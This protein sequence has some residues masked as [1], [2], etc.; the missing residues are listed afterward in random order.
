MRSC[1]SLALFVLLFAT[2]SLSVHAQLRAEKGLLNATIFDFTNQRLTLQGEWLWYDNQLL[3]PE[4]LAD[5]KPVPVDF[6]STFNDTRVSG[7]G[8]GFATYSLTVLVPNSVQDYAIELPQIYSSYRLWVNEA[9]VASNGE[10][11]LTAES[12]LPQWRPQTV[13]FRV[14]DTLK[15]VLQVAN[16]HHNKGGVKE[17]IYLGESNTMQ[18]KNTITVNSKIIECSV[19]ILLAVIFFIIYFFYGRKKVI[20]YFS[21]LCITWAVRSAFS[22]DY[23]FIQ[24]VPNF[25]WTSMVRIE[26]ITLYLT[27][28]WAIL[29]LS[30]LFAHEGSQIIK[31]VLVTLNSI[32]VAFTALN[33]PLYFTKLLAVYLVTSALLL[34]YGTIIVVRALIN[35]RIGSTFL[36]ISTLLAVALFSYD[37]ITYEGL[38]AYN[39]ILFSAGYFLIFALMAVALLLHLNI[40]KSSSDTSDMLTYKDLY[41]DGK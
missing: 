40:I 36:S 34:L 18:M 13:S 25:N 41:G 17:P 8:Q 24:L 20:V 19:L 14:K 30:R 37:I 33:P 3:T 39:S 2:S 28:I 10:P 9:L 11:G 38:F 32:F 31:Y 22:N 4:E 16:F 6:P 23:V 7:S 29:F 1:G 26:Y 12:T 35:D 5:S 21:L 15:L 27:M